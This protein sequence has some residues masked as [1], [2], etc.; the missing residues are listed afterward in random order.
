MGLQGGRGED[1]AGLPV[2][3]PAAE[4]AAPAPAPPA[5][6]GLIL[7]RHLATMDEGEIFAWRLPRGWVSYAVAA[8]KVDVGV[9]SEGRGG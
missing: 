6:I 5:A 1:V 8:A 2:A 3:A 9:K 4:K 7:A